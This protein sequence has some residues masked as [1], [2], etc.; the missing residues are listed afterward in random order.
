MERN[1][2]NPLPLGR[3]APSAARMAA[4][5]SRTPPEMNRLFDEVR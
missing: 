4:V 2:F 3:P 1:P 5:F